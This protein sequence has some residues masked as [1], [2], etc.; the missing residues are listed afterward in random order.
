MGQIRSVWVVF[1]FLGTAPAATIVSELRMNGTNGS[2]VFIDTAGGAWTAFGTA[3]ISTARSIAGGA[4]AWFAGDGSSV[5]NNSSGALYFPTQPFTIE[6]WIYPEASGLNRP[7][8]IY[9]AGRSNPDSGLGFDIRLHDREI[10]VWGLDGW[11]GGIMPRGTPYVEA[12]R[13]GHVALSVTSTHA[14]LFFNGVL[15]GSSPRSAISDGGNAFAIG[16]QSNFGGW[17][18]QGYI[19]EFRVWDEALWTADWP[20]VSEIPEPLTWALVATGIGGCLMRRAF[21]SNGS[22]P[23]GRP[24]RRHST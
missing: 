7:G 23:R 6:F 8:G 10:V 9:L 1:L 17:S 15:R 18:F 13:W 24:V 21:A 2:T 20:P 14:F 5:R 12:D 3:Q 16:Y 4:S 11:F 22:C 19:D